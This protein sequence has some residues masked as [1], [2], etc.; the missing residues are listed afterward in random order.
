MIGKLKIA[1]FYLIFDRYYDD[2]LT[3]IQSKDVILKLFE[4]R[5]QLIQLIFN[6]LVANAMLIFP[7]KLTTGKDTVPLQIFNGH[8]S[9]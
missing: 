3:P 7:H 2:H 5:E 4:V 1:D 6:D 8:V 9:C